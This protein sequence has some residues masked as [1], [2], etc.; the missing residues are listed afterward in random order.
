[1]FGNSSMASNSQLRTIGFEVLSSCIDWLRGRPSNIGIQPK[2]R[3][4]Y[5][6]PQTVTTG[7]LVYWPGILVGL[8]IV[9]LGTG[10]WIVRR[11]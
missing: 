11:R 10:V 1:V 6:L 7:K 3:E 4:L 2:K 8:A 9:G 5:R